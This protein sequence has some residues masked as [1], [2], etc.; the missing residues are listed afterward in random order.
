MLIEQTQPQK[1]FNPADVPVINPAGIFPVYANNAT[2][3]TGPHDLR[4]V[5]TEIVGEGAKAEPTQQLRAS[6]ALSYSQAQLLI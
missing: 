5:F 6:V 3:F 4:V 2:V 1:Q